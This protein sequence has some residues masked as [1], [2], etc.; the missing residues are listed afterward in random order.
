MVWTAIQVLMSKGCAELG[1]LGE[2]ALEAEQESQPQ[3]QSVTVL[4][5]AAHTPWGLQVN[6]P[7]DKCMGEL[8]LLL[9]RAVSWMRKRYPPPLLT[10]TTCCR[11]GTHPW[12]HESIRAGPVTNCSTWESRPW[13]LPEQHSRADVGNKYRRA[14]PKHLNMRGLALPLV[15]FVISWVRKRYTPSPP[16]AGR[17]AGPEVII[18]EEWPLFLTWGAQQRWPWM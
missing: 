6:L 10:L 11:Q 18:V 3:L 12:S 2:L 9:S 7:E 4:R 14:S 8:V 16:M 15:C 5:Q 1:I 17:R 13:T